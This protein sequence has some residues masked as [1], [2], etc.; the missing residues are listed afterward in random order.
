L[1]LQPYGGCVRAKVWAPAAAVAGVFVITAAVAIP[2]VLGRSGTPPP[3]AEPSAP[4][5]AVPTGIATMPPDTGAGVPVMGTGFLARTPRG[6]HLFCQEL[7]MADF[8]LGNGPE[9]GPAGHPC[10][11]ILVTASGIADDLLTRQV[12]EWRY[13]DRLAVR[14]IYHG[15]TLAVRSTEP[16]LPSVPAWDEPPIPCQAP[17]AGWP[18]GYGDSDGGINALAEFVRSHPER[19]VDLWQAHPDGKPAPPSYIPTRMVYVVGAV[20]DL[21]QAEAELRA[22]YAGSLCVYST[23]H[24]SADLDRIVNQL[25][26]INSVQI[27]AH[28][29]IETAGVA[30]TVAVLDEHALRV[31]NA[32]GGDAIRIQPPLLQY[33]P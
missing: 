23:T 25:Q 1:T 12:G 20:G 16:A 24:S 13:S 14:G 29:D 26:S 28:V 30:A 33:A 22:L 32:I 7:A 6:D 10:G 17:G 18:S 8:L 15:G 4:V 31:L 19:F 2:I 21:A 5:M 3:S 9:L 11:P 27:D